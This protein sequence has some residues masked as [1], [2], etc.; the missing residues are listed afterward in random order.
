MGNLIGVRNLKHSRELHI[1]DDGTYRYEPGYTDC[2]ADSSFYKIE[3]DK[4]FFRHR[5]YDKWETPLASDH[6]FEVMVKEIVS[7][8]IIEQIILKG[9]ENV[10]DSGTSKRDSK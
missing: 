6:D 2:K 4:V 5:P 10:I 1:F 9:E 3:G 7:L 8:H